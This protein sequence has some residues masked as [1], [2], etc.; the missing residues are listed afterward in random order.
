MKRLIVGIIILSLLTS[1]DSYHKNLKGTNFN[2]GWINLPEFTTINYND[3]NGGWLGVT[4]Q[5]ITDVY[6][7]EEYILA[8]RCENR[9]DSILGYYIIKILPDTTRPVPWKRY[10]LLTWEQYTRKR[11]SL[12]LEESQ[13]RHINLF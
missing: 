7:N 11:D 10:G 2:V 1:C 4:E 13:M 5:R 9:T 6:W 3:P 12:G 8:K